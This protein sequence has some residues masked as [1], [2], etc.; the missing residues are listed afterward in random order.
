MKTIPTT[1]TPVVDIDPHLY[2]RLQAPAMPDVWFDQWLNDHAAAHVGPHPLDRLS[3][4]ER[5]WVTELRY[6]GYLAHEHDLANDQLAELHAIVDIWIAYDQRR[7]TWRTAAD[8]Y[9]QAMV[10][11]RNEYA[12]R[13]LGHAPAARQSA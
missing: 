10:D 5:Q 8:T 13:I 9:V 1:T 6:E 7:E 4:Q 3:E 12:D 11:W 2:C